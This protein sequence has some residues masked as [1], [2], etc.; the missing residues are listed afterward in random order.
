[1]AFLEFN[2]YSKALSRRVSVNVLLPEVNKKAEGIGIGNKAGYK[3]LY[4]FHGLSGNRT[5]WMRRS[6]I[7]R[8]ADKYDIAVVMPEVGRSWYTDTAYGANYLTFVAEELPEV[9]R[10]YFKGM[11]DKR[12]DNFVAGLSM[13]GYGAIKAAL[14]YPDNFGG[15]ASLS[16]SLDIIRKNRTVNLDEW[17]AIFDFNMK[18]SYELE[19]TKHDLYALARENH[20]QG[21]KFPKMYIW[22]GTE[23]NPHL[24]KTNQDF[25]ALLN[26]LN[27]EHFYKESKGDHSWPWWDLHIQDALC[28]LFSNDTMQIK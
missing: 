28:F 3:T 21:L 23:D 15:C 9:C 2:Y 4:L 26:E 16:G 27:I 18:S 25:H 17:K 13:G 10:G 19:G 11:S 14:T 1:M 12:E 7:E 22:C 6:S 8:Y 24:L 5:D 20:K